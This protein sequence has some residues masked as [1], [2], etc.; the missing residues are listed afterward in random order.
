MFYSREDYLHICTLKRYTMI[1]EYL[2][3]A[4]KKAKITQVEAAKI[5]HCHRARIVKIE[6]GTGKISLQEL[7]QLTHAY[8]C[9]LLLI[10][11]KQL[12]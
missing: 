3:Q 12:I 9:K 2:K 5:I 7:E 11:S 1:H 10:E 8:G 4:R 6:A